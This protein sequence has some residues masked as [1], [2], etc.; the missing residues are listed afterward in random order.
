LIFRDFGFD[1]P[2][3]WNP[4]QAYYTVFL[5]QMHRKQYF[6]KKNNSVNMFQ[7]VS[8]AV[9]NGK[10]IPWYTNKPVDTV[11]FLEQHKIDKMVKTL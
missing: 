9:K 1:K 6:N 2:G 3:R 4:I 7:L 8:F 10:T 11:V 5:Q